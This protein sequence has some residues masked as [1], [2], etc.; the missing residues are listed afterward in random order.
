MLSGKGERSV[1]GEDCGSF[2]FYP[3]KN[4]GAYGDAG[5]MVTNN[6]ELANTVRMIAN[7]GQLVKHDHIIEGRNSRLDAI[8]ASVLSLKINSIE[9]WTNE[10][11]K[12]AEYYS[13]HLSNQHISVPTLEENERHVFHLY[14][15]K[16]KQRDRLMEYLKERQIGCAIHYPVA[17]PFLKHI[18]TGILAHRI[19]LLRLK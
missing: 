17:L 10:R 19:I 5:A 11:I 12:H 4:L 6:Q 14:V 8:Q 7:H 13:K 16:T 9:F 18:A 15:V 2:S 3:G 1:H